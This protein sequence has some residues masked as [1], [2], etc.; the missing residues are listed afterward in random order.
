M[1]KMKEVFI[2]DI[3]DN[4]Q[5]I[6]YDMLDHR[7]H[8]DDDY[9]YKKHLQKKAMKKFKNTLKTL[10][11]VASMLLT[12]ISY[13]Q[14]I[15]DTFSLEYIPWGCGS[16]IVSNET[17]RQDWWTFEQPTPPTK[18][19][20]TQ[21]NVTLDTKEISFYNNLPY[22]CVDVIEYGEYNFQIKNSL[23]NETLGEGLFYITRP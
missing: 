17:P 6:T 13:G 1:G 8:I 2:K 22:L 4:A 11:L 14:Y 23:T 19:I 9:Y 21:N 3:E 10:S 18:W 5:H 20:V 7:D 12:T 15:V 16:Q